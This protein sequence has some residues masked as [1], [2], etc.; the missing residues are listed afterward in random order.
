MSFLNQLKPVSKFSF[1]AMGYL[2]YYVI[3]KIR[4]D[5][6]LIFTLGILSI[7]CIFTG[8]TKVTAI[9][10]GILFGF[11]HNFYFESKK[12]DVTFNEK[13][14]AILKEENSFKIEFKKEVKRN[15]YETEFQSDKNKFTL[16]TKRYKK[17][18]TLPILLCD[19]RFL[20]IKK[21]SPEEEYFRFLKDFQFSYIQIRESKCKRQSELI[22]NRKLLRKKVED[23]L[24]RAG[25][26][27]Y[28]NDIA[29]GLFFGDASF[30]E[31]EFKEKV[32]EGGVLH[33]FAASG[34]HIGV[35]IGFIYFFAKQ[36]WIFNY[37]TERIIPLV[38]AFSYL[39]ILDFPVSLLRAYIFTATL[40]L[41]S[42]FFRKMKSIDLILVS[43]AIILC[44]DRENFLT[45]SFNLSYSA[46]CGILFLKSFLE[47]LAFGNFKNLFIENFTISISASLGTY[48]VLLFYFKTFSFGSIFLN[49]LL[50][51]L[52]SLLLPLLYVSLLFQSLYESILD[53]IFTKSFFGE[54]FYFDWLSCLE[55][56]FN[57]SFLNCF[58]KAGIEI[59]WIYSELLL[60][61]LAY[62]SE[63]LSV[64]VGFYRGVKESFRFHM[65][66]YFA[67]LAI[68]IIGFFILELKL[69]TKKENK[70]K[71]I[72]FR[73]L[74][75]LLT[76]LFIG[77][78]F[79][80][81]F[82][83]YPETK[84][85]HKVAKN[86]FAGSDYYLVREKNEIYLGGICKYS[87]YKIERHLRE[88]LCDESIESFYIEEETCLSLATLCK[89]TAPNVK[90]FSAKKLPD[91]ENQYADLKWD[92]QASKR[93][94]TQL[95]IFYPHLDS[96]S[97]LQKNSRV[98][99]GNILLLF[100]YKLQDNAKDWNENKNL[101]GINPDWNFIT[102]DE[103]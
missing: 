38:V 23:L 18:I 25:I 92:V 94:F 73:I 49:L 39:Y 16:I 44:I 29:M 87:H 63:T 20:S 22:D 82:V 68:L 77:S 62:L 81:G 95:L 9:L 93:N 56:E 21:V 61:T 50:V 41:G 43:S 47:K 1:F 17:D 84:K 24:D 31:N 48:P 15:F 28:A 64:N 42:L 88:N 100:A 66:I 70:R 13:Y 83:L 54:S 40:V 76:L 53:F 52:T 72:R 5:P 6:I 101:L 26:T 3:A 96:L 8:Y 14:F 65:G 30:L 59:F 102:P 4:L 33:L 60:R 36:I 80:F 89:K 10:I 19:S 35:F 37:Y 55:M 58:V 12:Q 32:R 98:D 57:F 69:F 34:L 46:V 2:S 99:K 74:L 45:L 78:F 7:A 85:E 86:I 97:Q 11:F 90:I 71:A 51:P 27:D 91:W 79:Y 103:L 75:S 67:L